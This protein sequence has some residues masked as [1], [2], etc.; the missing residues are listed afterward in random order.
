MAAISWAAVRAASEA[1]V[2]EAGLDMLRTIHAT[3]VDQCGS[4]AA[5]V[6]ERALFHSITGHE[7][8]LQE[9]IAELSQ[10]LPMPTP[11]E[12]VAYDL[13]ANSYLASGGLPADGAAD[14]GAS[15][16][17]DS[18]LYSTGGGGGGGSASA[19]ASGG[20]T[21]GMADARGAGRATP[22]SSAGSAAGVLDDGRAAPTAR[23]RSRTA[24][25]GGREQ[26]ECVLL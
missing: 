8:A 9:W 26:G 4:A 11:E 22:V 20:G 17:R 3:L 7:A 15:S 5:A 16:S 25:D 6:S 13:Y 2:R 14:D 23:G 21:G 1:A 10:K 24:A 19:S 12:G 18:S